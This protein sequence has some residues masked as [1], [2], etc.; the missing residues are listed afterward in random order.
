VPSHERERNVEFVPTIGIPSGRVADFAAVSVPVRW[1]I[2]CSKIYRYPGKRRPVMDKI[3]KI[4]A[5]TDLS[6]LSLAGMRYALDMARVI[7]AEVTVYYVVGAEELMRYSHKGLLDDLIGKYDEALRRFVEVHCSDLLPLVD[8][9][10]KVELGT[11][12]IN[13]VEGAK[14]EGSD[15]IVISTHGRTGL[16]HVLVGSVTERVVRHAPCPVLSIHPDNRK[17]APRAAA[18]A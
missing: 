10:T 16:S 4:L 15:L 3:K 1:H 11:A 9:H 5:P 17:P 6:D 12:D 8:I 18:A 13:I 7:G 14:K 2:L